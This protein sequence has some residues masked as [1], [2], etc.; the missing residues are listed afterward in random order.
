MALLE[1]SGRADPKRVG[2]LLRDDFVE[3]GS[4]GRLYGKEMLVEML[5]REEPARVVI[6]D[7][8]VRDLSPDAALATYR[9]VGQTRM[10]DRW[11][12]I[13]ILER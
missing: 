11:G 12:P 5:S 10:P 8:A 1:P 2:A 6:R 9:S 4:S 13:G 3:F 7:L